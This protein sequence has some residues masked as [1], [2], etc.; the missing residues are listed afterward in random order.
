M[1]RD[2]DDDLA[3]RSFFSCHWMDSAEVD[4][5][6]FLFYLQYLTYGGLGSRRSQLSALECLNTCLLDNITG[7]Y[8]PE[9][10]LNLVG[11]CLELEGHSQLSVMVYRTSLIVFPRNNAANWH[12]RR[13]ERNMQN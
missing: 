5:K 1:V 7:V 8:H 11:H 13:L 6:P 9:T 10:V 4:A 3:Y 2:V 12:L